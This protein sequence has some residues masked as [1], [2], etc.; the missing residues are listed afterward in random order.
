MIK[1]TG[2]KRSVR[3]A[4]RVRE[5]IA[6]ALARDLSDPRLEH[7]VVT[8]VEVP[9]DL[10]LSR[11]FVRLAAG[12]DDARRARLLAGLNAAKDCPK[13]G[14]EKR[15][16]S[17]RLSSASSTTKART[18]PSAS[19]ESSTRSNSNAPNRKATAEGAR[20]EGRRFRLRWGG[21]LGAGWGWTGAFGGW[22]RRVDLPQFCPGPDHVDAQLRP[23]PQAS[24]WADRPL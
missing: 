16:P 9:D 23:C 13:A 1:P 17:L 15:R 7:V 3:V 11:I 20:R 12:N 22:G 2:V 8:R 19:I 4:E 10:S 6:R 21:W 14:R 18:P 24:R 5:E